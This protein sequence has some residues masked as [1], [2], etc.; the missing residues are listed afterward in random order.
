MKTDPTERSMPA[1][2]TTKVCPTATKASSTPLLAAVWIAV[3]LNPA[4]C[5]SV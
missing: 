4:G 3:A 1:V 2:S 5:F